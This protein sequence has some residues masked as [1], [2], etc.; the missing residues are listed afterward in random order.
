MHLDN[1]LCLSGSGNTNENIIIHF[2]WVSLNRTFILAQALVRQ[3]L[4]L[5]CAV[6]QAGMESLNSQTQIAFRLS[7]DYCS[8]ISGI[9]APAFSDHGL[10]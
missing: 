1:P 4:G 7:S 2:M 5:A 10:C 8:F 3:A 6:E 9:S